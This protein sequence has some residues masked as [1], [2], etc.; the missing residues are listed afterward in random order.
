MACGSQPRAHARGRTAAPAPT[1]ESLLPAALLRAGAGPEAD[2][3]TSAAQAM[4]GEVN[5]HPFKWLVDG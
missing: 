2:V 3:G 5:R 1:E 4:A